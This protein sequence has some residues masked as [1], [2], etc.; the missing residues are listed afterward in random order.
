MHCP[1]E[2]LLNLQ[3]NGESY[4]ICLVAFS[5]PV[6]SELKVWLMWGN[7]LLKEGCIFILMYYISLSFC[8]DL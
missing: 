2:V 1:Q 8:C 3:V 6:S 7:G 4:I 5:C